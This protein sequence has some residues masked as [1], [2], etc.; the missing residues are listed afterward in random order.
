MK[1]TINNIN[2]LTK[3]SNK[4]RSKIINKFTEIQ[5]GHPG[6]ILSILD[7]VT[8]IYTGKYLKITKNLKKND[9]LIISKGHAASVQYPF[10]IDAG[11]ISENEWTNWSKF[12]KK[13]SIFRIF[14]NTDIKGI[15]ATTGSLGH[16]IGI[17]AGIAFSLKKKGLNKKV[18]VI[19]SEGELYE[20]STWESL[21]F[22]SHHKLNNL[23]IIIDR[24]NLIILG[25]TE[26]CLKLEPIAS[27][28]HSFGFK[29][30]TI[31]GHSFKEIIN[32]L[33]FL[34]KKESK[35]KVLIANT[36][37]GRGISFMENKP[38]WHYWQKL[39]STQYIKLKTENS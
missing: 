12:S 36:I 25:K 38:E 31:N 10:L 9:Y 3:I 34:T 20:G 15:N 32:G 24:N 18:F 23:H 1:P 5:E 13:K 37:K 7:I 22:A 33:N 39:N 26:E 11:L 14:G 29:S 28:I 19:I 8:S 35:P 2:K 27:K 6:S 21:M 16:G 17:G 30:K 4:F